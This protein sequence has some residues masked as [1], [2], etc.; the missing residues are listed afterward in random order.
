[1]FKSS[2]FEEL[3]KKL[4]AS[5]PVNFENIEDDLQ[6]K[7]KSILQGAFA[8]LNLVSREEFD[9]QTKVLARTREKVDH[10]NAQIELLLQQKNT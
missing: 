5:I 6:N 2:Q 7:F 3:T 1:M 4:L 10:L 8:H 9:V